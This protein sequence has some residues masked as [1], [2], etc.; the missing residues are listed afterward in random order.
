M[1]FL[2]SPLAAW[3]SKDLSNSNSRKL[4]HFLSIFV[5]IPAIDRNWKMINY[6]FNCN[7]AVGLWIE[8]SRRMFPTNPLSRFIDF[9]FTLFTDSREQGYLVTSHLQLLLGCALPSLLC[10]IVVD[11]GQPDGIIKAWS[12]SGILLLGVG[13]SVSAILGKA[14]GNARWRKE[15]MKTVEGSFYGTM[16]TSLAYYICVSKFFPEF[17][18]YQ[19]EVFLASVLTFGVEGYTL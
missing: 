14:I 10:F 11:G 13:D 8:I 17:G 12:I 1:I 4:F 19:L 7:V 18:N 9:F 5:F 6:A 15:N 3:A 2:V 16:G